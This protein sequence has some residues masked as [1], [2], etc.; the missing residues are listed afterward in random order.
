M[1]K[2]LVASNM[3]ICPDGAVADGEV[4]G[5]GTIATCD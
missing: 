2:I 1:P 5:N 4:K 3:F